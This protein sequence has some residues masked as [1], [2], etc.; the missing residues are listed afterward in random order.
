MLNGAVLLI[1]KFSD[2]QTL[3]APPVAQS[4]QTCRTFRTLAGHAEHLTSTVP[5]LAGQNADVMGVLGMLRDVGLMVAAEDIC[6]RLNTPVS[7]PLD[8]P[9]SRCFIITCDR[10]AAV[11]R[12][13]ESMLRASTLS[14]HQALSR[15]PLANIRS[16]R[17][18]AMV[19]SS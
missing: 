14:R 9:P 6:E 3:V 17:R 7:P 15:I 1:D 11:E 19:G 16:A 2:A 12:L 5:E 18:A 4:M 8:L 13:L 10:P